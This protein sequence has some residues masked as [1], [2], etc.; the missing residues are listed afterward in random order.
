[1]VSNILN[2]S[3]RSLIWILL[4]H[5]SQQFPTPQIFPR[6]NFPTTASSQR[7]TFQSATT[8]SQP[9]RRARKPTKHPLRRPSLRHRPATSRRS[10]NP[11]YQ[12]RLTVLGE[13]DSSRNTTRSPKTLS[14][15]SL[16]GFMFSPTPSLLPSLFLASFIP[17]PYYYL[18]LFHSN[19]LCYR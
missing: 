14:Q 7:S 9:A 12:R 16:V 3:K 1:M 6:S 5:N 10:A 17:I 2:S 4:L 8:T 13:L 15:V 11:P 18:Q 19:G